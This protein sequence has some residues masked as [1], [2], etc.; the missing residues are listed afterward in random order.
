M[1]SYLASYPFNQTCHDVCVCATPNAAFLG[2][3][4]DFTTMT[5]SITYKPHKSTALAAKRCHAV[6]RPRVN[7][8]DHVTRL[9]TVTL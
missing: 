4:H 3:S 5:H 2:G 7:K 8:T 6:K 1:G 9:R